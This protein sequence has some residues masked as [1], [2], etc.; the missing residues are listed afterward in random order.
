M[1]N[2]LKNTILQKT[3]WISNFDISLNI[4]FDKIAYEIFENNW[5]TPTRITSQYSIINN[6]Q[7]YN[8]LSDADYICSINYKTFIVDETYIEN[9]IKN[10]FIN[11]TQFCIFYKK[12]N[13]GMEILIKNMKHKELNKR[14]ILL[15]Q[16][17]Y[18]EKDKDKDTYLL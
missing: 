8:D 13:N 1:Y 7:Y 5:Y 17:I 9:F 2:R 16:I 15:N 11:T 6:P 4:P 12:Y 14:M 10:Y 18:K 3:Y